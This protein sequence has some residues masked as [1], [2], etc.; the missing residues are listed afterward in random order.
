MQGSAWTT[1]EK[2]RKKTTLSQ[3]AVLSAPPTSAMGPPATTPARLGSTL[4]STQASSSA[5]PRPGAAS[6]PTNQTSYAAAV[7]APVA[8]PRPSR[9]VRQ[10]SPPLDE[11]I[12]HFSTFYITDFTHAISDQSKTEAKEYVKLIIQTKHA[13]YEDVSSAFHQQLANIDP[14]NLLPQISPQEQV[15]IFKSILKELCI[16]RSPLELRQRLHSMRGGF[17]SERPP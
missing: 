6:T 15:N 16:A 9:Q 17:V 10:N 3:Q 4:S 1:I 13:L 7:A 2:Q 5:A 8:S 11:T 12:G 14:G